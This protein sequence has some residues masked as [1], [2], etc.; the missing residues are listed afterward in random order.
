MSAI[1]VVGSLNVDLS[2]RVT[3]LPAPG[4]TVL[5]R[6][7]AK[8]FGGKGGNQAVAAAALGA[9]VSFIGAVGQD[10]AGETYLEHLRRAGVDVDGVAQHA[11][12]D[13]GT[14]M[15]FV[16]DAGENLI[17]V[18]PGANSLLD[19]AWVEP[20]VLGQPLGVVLLQLEVP[21]TALEA[22][23]AALPA[24]TVLV[25][26]PA[27]MPPDAGALRRLLERVDV[28]VPNR[29]ELGQLAGTTEPR[30]VH[31]VRECLSAL[32]FAGAVI[33]TLG[34]DGAILV[35]AGTEPVH[36][37]A[38]QLEPVDTTGAGD[39]FCGALAVGLSEG[40]ALADAVV[41]AVEVAGRSTLFRGAQLSIAPA[42]SSPG[43]GAS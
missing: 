3:T 33:V 34:A 37:A 40:R 29:T 38:L 21:L 43:G 8:A 20:K 19:A 27:P 15:I 42:S 22:A 32:D 7:R 23:A 12:V 4:E 35:E 9:Q 18:D 1:G 16:D 26:N 28:L 30:T 39:A 36:H 13:T 31:E 14:A 11:E 17:V 5:A 24:E 6:D 41:R 25:L 10:E 2:Y